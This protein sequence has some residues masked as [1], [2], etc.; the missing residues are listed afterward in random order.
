MVA[1]SSGSV[2]SGFTAIAAYLRVYEP[3][4]AFPAD[5]R[6]WWRAVAA[7]GPLS[8][9]E[10]AARE[11]AAALRA[12]TALPPRVV[13]DYDVVD[14]DGDPARPV[15]IVLQP[16]AVDGRLRVCPIELSW[17]SLLAL[18]EFQ[19]DVAPTVLP[20]FVPMDVVDSASQQ[21]AKLVAERSSLTGP[22]VRNCRWSVPLVWFAGFQPSHRQ[23]AE[24]PAS[25]APGS[26]TGP[27]AA[28][29]AP[30]VPGPGQ[31]DTEAD[32]ERSRPSVREP[33][34]ALRY[35]APMADARRC[36]ARAIASVRVTPIALLPLAELEDLGRWLEEFHA[37]SVV[38]LDY[39]GLGRLLGREDA[40]AADSVA[41]VSLGLADLRAGRFDPASARLSAVR[42][43]W[44]E[45][46]AH[47]HAS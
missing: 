38:E 24:P 26:A 35:L 43:L 19:S 17:R 6:A 28:T 29:A 2:P 7:S 22:H 5:E 32:A 44:D 13:T 33:A 40:A 41:E 47:E 34:P 23:V 27:P 9:A 15:G 8:A 18:E 46:G 3:L 39:A 11:H 37:R 20:A 30:A 12:L 4:E 21:L 10:M 25:D 16:A 31:K 36:M 42:D 14:G 45:I 1:A